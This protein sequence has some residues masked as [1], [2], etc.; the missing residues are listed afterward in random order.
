MKSY[1]HLTAFIT[2][3][4]SG[5]GRAIAELFAEAQMRLILTGRRQDRLDLMKK[6][7]SEKTQIYTLNFDVSQKQ[8]V[9]AAIATLPDSW[10]NINIL[11]N[12]AGNAHGLAPFQDGSLDDWEAMIDINIKGILYVTKEILPFMK[13]Q[14]HKH[15]LN[16]GSIAGIE[17][18]PNGNVYCASKRAVAALSEA[19]RIDL[20]KEGIRVSEIKPG[21]VETEFSLVRFKGDEARAAQVY[22]NYSPLQAEDIAEIAFF[23]LTR[24]AHVNIAD[25]LVLPTDQAKSTI[26][27]KKI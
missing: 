3:A 23:I 26:I 21:L 5:I 24:P 19:L 12:N 8:A 1:S 22:Q 18:Y 13:L 9:K 7:L 25:L 10:K 2:G 6:E 11:V 4:T 17:V 16:I 20:L 15:I 27:N 14:T